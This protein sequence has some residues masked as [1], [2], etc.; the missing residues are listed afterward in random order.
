MVYGPPPYTTVVYSILIPMCW[1]RLYS[2][3]H[4]TPTGKPLSLSNLF[5][6]DGI[7]LIQYPDVV[8]TDKG[9]TLHPSPLW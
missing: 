6:W 9:R 1:Y 2:T 8:V 5:L 4:S 7:V 3:V